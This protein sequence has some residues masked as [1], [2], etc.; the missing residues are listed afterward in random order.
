MRNGVKRSTFRPSLVD[1]ILLIAKAKVGGVEKASLGIGCCTIRRDL[2][3]M[4]LVRLTRPVIG[5]LCATRVRTHVF[6]CEKDTANE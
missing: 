4:S 3:D 2:V 5:S 1:D 6:G